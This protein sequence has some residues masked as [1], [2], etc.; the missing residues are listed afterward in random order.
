MN[1]QNIF[2]AAII[3]RKKDAAAEILRVVRDDLAKTEA[4]LEEKR[5]KTKMTGGGE[6]ILKEDEVGVCMK[7]KK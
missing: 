4:A 6:E 5:D 2:Q 1:W 3:H 7:I